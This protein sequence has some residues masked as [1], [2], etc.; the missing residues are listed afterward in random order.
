MSGS[1]FGEAY[2]VMTFGESHGPFIGVVI[3]GIQPG[4]EID[5]EA[6]QFQL[7]RRKPGQSDVVTPRKEEDKVQIVSGVFEGKTTGTPIC[8]L[9]KNK[10]Q[11]SRDYGNIVKLFRP[12]HASYT[13]LQK[14]GVFDY[15]GGGRASGRE[16]ATRVASGALARQLLEARGV[17]IYG[18]TRRV[19]DIE[20]EQVD[21][22]VIEKNPVRAADPGAA[23]KMAE[24]IR[25]A[26]DEGDSIGGVVEVVVRNCPPGLG[27]PVFNKLQADLAGALMSIGA[28]KAFE[29]GSGFD[30]AG[31]KGSDNNDEFYYSEDSEAFKTRTNN[32]GGVLGG[33]SNGEDLVMR[34]TVKPPSSISKTQTTSDHDGKDV[35][36]SI[37]GRHD[38]CICPRVV[39]VA[40]AMV[41]LV[42]LDHLLMQERL[43]NEGAAE[44]AEDKLA[45]IDQQIL[46]L[47]AQRQRLQKEHAS[48]ASGKDATIEQ[49]EKQ[50]EGLDLPNELLSKLADVLS[51]TKK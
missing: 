23:E 40:E 51:E 38:P 8:M 39:P 24:L 20:I 50:S 43:T 33:I 48:S 4:I 34:I 27:E 12:G 32:A 28:I 42:L 11:R 3:D 21:F 6:I 36:F 30:T 25:A 19:G 41:A 26:R 45:T 44:V 18:Y 2:R 13:F 22:D 35:E 46:L 49:L 47:L 31:L 10:D 17:E 1:R 9:I 14:Y 37:G 7:N 5:E 15:R 29:M 16:T